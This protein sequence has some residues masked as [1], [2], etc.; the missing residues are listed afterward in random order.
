MGAPVHYDLANFVYVVVGSVRI[1]GWSEDG[2]IEFEDS[3]PIAEVTTGADG[4]DTIS[5]NNDKNMNATITVKHGSRAYKLLAEQMDDQ[6][7]SRERGVVPD[8]LPFLAKDIATGDEI[9][10]AYLTYLERPMFS[11]SKQAGDKVFKV[12]LSQVKRIHGANL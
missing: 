8:T 2:G 1:E 5:Y 3:A 6:T 11:G 9:S 12:R 7:E 4:Q 10:A